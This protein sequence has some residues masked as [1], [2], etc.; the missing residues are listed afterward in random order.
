LRDRWLLAWMKEDF[1]AGFGKVVENYWS[2][3]YNFAYRMLEGS[4]LTYLAE[5]AIQEGLFSAYKDLR[6]NRQKLD[7]LHLRNWLYVIV[8]QKTID[9]LTQENKTVCLAGLLGWENGGEDIAASRSAD[10]TSD[11]AYRLERWETISEAR[12]T[13]TELLTSLSDAQREVIVL[14]YSSQDGTGSE[15][16][17]YQQIAAKLN[18]PV[19]TVKSDVSRA[20]QHMRKRLMEQ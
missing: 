6:H 8:R 16:I 10:A 14:K 11:P 9:C 2:E 13:V 18:K 17:P 4:G 7:K 12:R 15:E 19:G 1:D 3:L 5:D 20:M